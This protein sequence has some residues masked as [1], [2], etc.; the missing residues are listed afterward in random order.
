MKQYTCKQ[1]TLITQVL[2]SRSNVFLLSHQRRHILIDTCWHWERASLL[3]RLHSLGIR[4]LEAIIL[5]HCHFDHAD[6]AAYIR[7]LFS[8]KVLVSALEADGL[9]SGHIL[10]PTGSILFTKCIL[11]MLKPWANKQ[12]TNLTCPADIRIGDEFDMGI[13]GF[14]AKIISTPGHS[15]GSQS[16]IVENDIAIVGDAMFGLLPGSIFPPFADDIPKLYQ[17]WKKLLDT[18]CRL[19]L[20]SHGTPNSRRLVERCYIKSQVDKHYTLKN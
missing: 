19:F 2:N 11:K 16:V 7:K 14:N 3:R 10:A 13:F 1:G 8:T 15:I 5:T 18:D 4:N 17:S 12:L 9:E 6:N 20:P